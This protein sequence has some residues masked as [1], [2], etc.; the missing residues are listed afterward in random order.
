MKLLL[1]KK[2]T[3]NK[4]KHPHKTSLPP[5]KVLATPLVKSLAKEL[6]L[7]LSTIKGTGVH[8]KILKVD[9]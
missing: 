9:V 5:Q 3:P 2:T 1:Q 7:D 4:H 6:G 8:G